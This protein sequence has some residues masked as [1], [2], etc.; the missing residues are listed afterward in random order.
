MKSTFAL[1]I[2]LV[3]GFIAQLFLPWWIIAVVCFLAGFTFIDE[4]KYGFLV[5]FFGVFFLWAGVAIFKSYGNDFILL[6]R[7][8]ELLGLSSKW[9]VLL[10]TSVL[11][12]L[13]GMLSTLSGYFLQTI[14]DK[15]KKQTRRYS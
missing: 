1:L 12:G 14:N 5:G 3:L 8:G 11:G 4:A 13:I 7:M 6:Q 9:L 2:I 15:P 10:A